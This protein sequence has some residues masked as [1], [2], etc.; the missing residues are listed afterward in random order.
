MNNKRKD[1]VHVTDVVA[2]EYKRKSYLDLVALTAR[3]DVFEMEYEGR[4]YDFEIEA[5]QADANTVY[6]SVGSQR[7]RL[8]TV[9]YAIYF[10]KTKSGDLIEESKDV[11]F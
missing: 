9:G 3:P 4:T 8:F 11:I 7:H 5:K 6:V 1:L 10:G 2:D